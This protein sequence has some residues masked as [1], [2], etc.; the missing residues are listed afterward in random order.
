MATHFSILTWKIAG[1]EELV[2]YSPWGPQK[3]NTTECEYTHIFVSSKKNIYIYT[4]KHNDGKTQDY[5]IISYSGWYWAF[6]MALLLLL[7]L[8]LL[9]RFSRVRPC[10]TP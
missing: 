1:T 3:S 10:V 7:L 8:L 9:S 5:E 6:Q 2:G 4:M